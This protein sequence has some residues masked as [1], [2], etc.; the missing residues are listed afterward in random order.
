MYHDTFAEVPSKLIVLRSK[1][2]ISYPESPLEGYHGAALN[3]VVR[4]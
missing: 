3:H 1:H 2:M 4:Y